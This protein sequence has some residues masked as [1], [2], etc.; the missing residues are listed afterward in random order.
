M[1]KSM[2]RTKLEYDILTASVGGVA[3]RWRSQYTDANRALSGGR[4]VKEIQDALDALA[5]DADP[6]LADKVIG[7][8]SWTHPYCSCCSNYVK[9]AVQFGT[10]YPVVVCEPCMKET[11]KELQ[12]IA[13]R[14]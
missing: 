7:N 11:T 10:D 14:S 3:D 13:S 6:A 1:A 8:Q 12:R 5:S 2:K 9:A 4:S